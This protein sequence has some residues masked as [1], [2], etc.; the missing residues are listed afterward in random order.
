M[1]LFKSK[2]QI[3]GPEPG[4]I[5][6]ELERLLR[7]LR[8]L[9]LA[10]PLLLVV[11]FSVGELARVVVRVPSG[12]AVREA[13]DRSVPELE[14]EA[15]STR[16]K[17]LRARGASTVD[18]VTMYREHVQPVEKVLRKRGLP[19]GTARRISWPLVEE[20]YRKG[21]DPATV[22]AIMMVESGGKS[23]AR[24]S[25]GAR[26]LMQVMP[27]WAGQWPGCGRDLYDIED[28]ILPRHQHSPLVQAPG[29]YGAAGS[30]GLQRLRARD[31]YTQ[32]PH[33]PRQDLAS[34]RAD[35]RGN[36]A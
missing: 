16:M 2:P 23:T 9:P 30:A 35:Q 34:A 20:S 3:D 27:A 25:V 19:S 1:P 11:G 12:R 17:S 29:R 24:S 26:G 15:L 28:N 32:L 21:L 13:G 5:V 31:Q 22:V 7:G 10:A 33:L 36:H 6:H 14:Y 4:G 8:A 18:Y